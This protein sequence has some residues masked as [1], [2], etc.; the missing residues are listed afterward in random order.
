MSRH[1]REEVGFNMLYY[2]Y[3]LENTLT[4]RHYVGSTNDIDRRLEEHNRGHTK[5][6]RSRGKWKL[7]YV[8]KYNIEEQARKRER[9]IKSYKGG[10]AFKKLIAGVV[11]R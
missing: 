4:K 5:S 3:V 9:Q 2:T 6:T 1:R 10:G 8:E 11:H 7:L